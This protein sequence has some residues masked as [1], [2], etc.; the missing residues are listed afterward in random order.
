MLPRKRLMTANSRHSCICLLAAVDLPIPQVDLNIKNCT[1]YSCIRIYEDWLMAKHNYISVEKSSIYPEYNCI[2]SNL[3]R[4]APMVKLDVFVLQFLSSVFQPLKEE[5]LYYLAVISHELYILVNVRC[6][7]LLFMV[8]VMNQLAK[9]EEWIYVNDV[10]DRAILY[11]QSRCFLVEAGCSTGL[12]RNCVYFPELRPCKTGVDHHVDW[13]YCMS[14]FHLSNGTSEEVSCNLCN[15]FQ[16][17]DLLIFFQCL[18]R[19]RLMTASS[20][21]ILGGNHCKLI[22]GF[23]HTFDENTDQYMNEKIKK[24]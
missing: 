15:F 16:V 20:F 3:T 21:L 14:R 7:P 11:D 23:Y 10:G 5:H 24:L 17:N 13:F 9:K 6:G 19:E 2:I 8:Y 12:E 1:D 18:P 4:C 22:L